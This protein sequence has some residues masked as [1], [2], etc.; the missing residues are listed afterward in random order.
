MRLVDLEPQEMD[1]GRGAPVYP[2]GS[3]ENEQNILW[4]VSDFTCADPDHQDR[5][6]PDCESCVACARTNAE[7][8]KASV[9]IEVEV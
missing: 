1:G 4:R 2:L 3:T 7:A 9:G 6:H 5:F 8:V